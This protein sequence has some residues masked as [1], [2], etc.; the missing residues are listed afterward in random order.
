M[1]VCIVRLAASSSSS[2]PEALEPL[3]LLSSSRLRGSL[4]SPGFAALLLCFLHV[5]DRRRTLVVAFA[6]GRCSFFLLRFVPDAAG[7]IGEHVFNGWVAAVSLLNSGV[8]DF[9]LKSR[10]LK[11]R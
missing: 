7:A 2:L 3:M 4:I 8:L 11:N 5:A 1:G 9:F 6:G 10:G